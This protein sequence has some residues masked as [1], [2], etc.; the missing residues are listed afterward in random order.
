MSVKPPAPFDTL[1]DVVRVDGIKVE[2]LPEEVFGSHLRPET[3]IAE[4]ADPRSDRVS[5]DL[6]TIVSGF[7]MEGTPVLFGLMSGEPTYENM[8]DG[9]RRYRNQ[10]IIARSWL[11]ADAANLQL[12]LA[13][14]PG[15]AGDDATWHE[16]AALIEADDRVCRKVVWLPPA[17]SVRESAAEFLSRTFLASPWKATMVSEAAPLDSMSAIELPA[18]WD[19]IVSDPS[20]DADGIV[21]RLLETT[22]E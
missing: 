13:A 10:A 2:D 11:D 7:R 8:R 19:E 21:L 20:L 5:Q 22:S 18:G 6:P 16:F 3:W 1:I 17:D 9:L 14:P 15:A 12:F 4:A